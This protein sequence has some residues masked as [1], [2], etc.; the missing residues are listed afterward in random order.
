MVT[1]DSQLLHE[2][3]SSISVHLQ[4][5]PNNWGE[6]YGVAYENEI[7]RIHPFCW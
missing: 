5:N 1:A 2:F 6:K 7:F 4:E 3:L